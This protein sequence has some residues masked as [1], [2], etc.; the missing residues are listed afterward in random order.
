MAY[1]EAPWRLH[2]ELILVPTWPPGRGVM[3]ARYT[4]GTLAYH[5]LIAFSHTTPRGAV[6]SHIYVDD[7]R[8]LHGGI[9]I[10]GLPKQLATFTYERDRFTARQGD[11]TLLHAWIRR[12]R[13]RLPLTLPTPFTSHRGVTIGRARIKGALALVKLEVPHNSPIAHLRLNGTH[14]ALAGDELDLTIPPPHAT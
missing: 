7:E 2:G 11:V 12:R 10:W 13:G 6:I 5:E 9:E 1:P 4:G 8:S 14:L 3:L